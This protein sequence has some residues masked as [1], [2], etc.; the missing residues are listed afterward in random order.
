[1]LVGT[2]LSIEHNTMQNGVRMNYPDAEGPSTHGPTNLSV[3]IA[4]FKP[5]TC[6]HY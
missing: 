3:A 6:L 2:V 1:V 5:K 4:N